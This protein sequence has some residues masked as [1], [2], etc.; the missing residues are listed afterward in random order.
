MGHNLSLFTLF[1]IT[2]FVLSQTSND[3][4]A[5]YEII[6][7][8]SKTVM[9]IFCS[10]SFYIQADTIDTWELNQSRVFYLY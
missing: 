4:N 6:F 2:F 7:D 3:K 1:K 10:V 5:N 8:G 9:Q